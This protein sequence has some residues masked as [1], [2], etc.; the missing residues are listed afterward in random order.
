M[1]PGPASA[2]LI[3]T[4]ADH[5]YELGEFPLPLVVC[6]ADGGR[7]PAPPAASD[8]L[9]VRQ[10]RAGPGRPAGGRRR[11]GRR[12]AASSAPGGRPR[13]VCL[14]RDGRELRVV[15]GAA[16][17]AD[18]SVA[19]L[20]SPTGCDAAREAR[21][22]ELQSLVAHDLRSPLA[23]IQGYAGL[24][25]TELAGPLNTNQREFVDGIDLKIAE[26]V[27]LLDDFLDYQRLET[28][29]LSLHREPV[30]VTDLVGEL[31]EEYA[32]RAARRGLTLDAD[33]A[34][35]DLTVHADP[36]RLR[37]ILDALVGSA[38]GSADEGT[39]IRISGRREGRHVELSVGD[40]GPAVGADELAGLFDPVAR[41][42]PATSSRGMGL[43]FLVVRQLV[44][45]HGGAIRADSPANAG[46]RLR[47]EPAPGPAAETA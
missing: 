5:T 4:S 14:R 21:R 24:L 11:G 40:G 38:V 42:G 8:L 37:Q 35:P 6:A 31:M 27:R 13:T 3:L 28:G 22:A 32:A 18:G 45:C 16:E 29:A 7:G 10:R 19:Y 26:L 47:G 44:T 17:G 20:V 36:V 41:Q 1:C 46:L 33:I 23:V 43:G 39:W 15:I 30:V 34:E 2:T 12:R 25:A 9:G